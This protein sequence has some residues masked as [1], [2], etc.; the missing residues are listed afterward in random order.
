MKLVI[1]KI[2]KLEIAV[3]VLEDDLAI[4][5]K[6]LNLAKENLSSMQNQLDTLTNELERLSSNNSDS[7]TI[8]SVNLS[9]E[10]LYKT[11]LRQAI[12]ECE[13]QIGI[14]ELEVKAKNEDVRKLVAKK[15]ASQSMIARLR[16]DLSKA[17]DKAQQEVAELMHTVNNLV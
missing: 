16:V 9:N 3:K 5:A 4:E 12:T 1:K 6:L 2:E 15:T 8:S 14:M 10:F 13:R 7:S 11:K 17:E